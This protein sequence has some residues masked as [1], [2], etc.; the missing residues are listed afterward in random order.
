[1]VSWLSGRKRRFAKPL[2]GLTVPKVRILHSPPLIGRLIQR[3]NASFT[4]KK[5]GV[6]ISHRP[7]FLE[8]AS[9]NGY[10]VALPTLG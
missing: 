1:M 7:P 6:Q 4:P 2:N 3:E 10:Y 8:R 9:Y 5:S